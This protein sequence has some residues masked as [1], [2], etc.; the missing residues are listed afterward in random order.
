MTHVLA[1]R[2]SSNYSCLKNLG[3]LMMS[4]G[5]LPNSDHAI[6]SGIAMNIIL[7]FNHSHTPRGTEASS[8][9]PGTGVNW[10]T[11]RKVM[12]EHVEHPNL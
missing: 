12:Q 2:L 7:I 8:I 11:N 3:V 9:V 4:A 6:F 5:H 1:G 10:S